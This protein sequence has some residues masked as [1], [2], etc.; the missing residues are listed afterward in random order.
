MVQIYCIII[1]ENNNVIQSAFELSM[2]GYFE[3]SLMEDVCL[4]ISKECIK[5][6]IPNKIN[7]LEKDKYVCYSI[8]KNNMGYSCVCDIDYPSRI[9]I[10]FLNKVDNKMTKIELKNLLLEHCDI[11]KVDKISAIHKELDDTKKICYDTINKLIIRDDEL[12]DL[13]DKTDDLQFQ[14]KMFMNETDKLNSCCIII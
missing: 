1:I 12:Q 11:T 3:R 13:V 6:G 4:I 7:S 5:I 14:T 2:F 10:D 9:A 8:S